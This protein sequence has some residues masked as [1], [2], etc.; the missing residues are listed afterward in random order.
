MR[1]NQCRFPAPAHFL[2]LHLADGR[3]GFVHTSGIGEMRFS[4]RFRR[5]IEGLR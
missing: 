3:R 2:R 5:S 1:R 4:G